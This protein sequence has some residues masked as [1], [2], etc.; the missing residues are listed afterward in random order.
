MAGKKKKI[1]EKSKAFSGAKKKQISKKSN[2]KVNFNAMSIVGFVLCF[3]S[4]FAI[5]GIVLE[6]IALR[7]I[8]KTNQRGRRLAIVG[9][10]IGILVLY[11]TITS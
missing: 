8:S 11:V 3:L 10:V 9:L 7:Q 2:S 6:V 5:L 4:W 1:G